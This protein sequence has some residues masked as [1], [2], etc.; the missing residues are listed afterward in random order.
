MGKKSEGRPALGTKLYRSTNS[1]STWDPVPECKRIDGPNRSGARIQ[2]TNHD[3]P[4]GVHEYATG[5]RDSGTLSVSGN[6]VP[7]NAIHQAIITDQR[8]G[9]TRRWKKVH[10]GPAAR[11]STFDGFVETVSDT[12]DY[13]GVEEWSFS[14]TI[15]G[16]ITEGNG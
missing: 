10:P 16:E 3:S 2:I 13:A 5:I 1:G 6:Y 9:T 4:D 11:S 15:T 8:D 7:H 14:I 12:D